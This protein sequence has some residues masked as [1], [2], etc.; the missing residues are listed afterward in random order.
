M[1][2]LFECW[3]RVS[4]R[5]RASKELRV[6]LDFDGTLV[7]YKPHPNEVELS[8]KTAR[9]LGK[10]AGHRSVRVAIVSGRR[11]DAL[12]KYVKVR[13]VK[14]MGM[15]GWENGTS[16]RLSNGTAEQIRNFRSG[17]ATLPEDLPGVSV[18]DKGISV[19]VHFRGVSE[20]TKRRA[21]DRVRMG[22][23]L[24]HSDLH[25]IRSND[26]WDVAPTQVRGKGEALRKALKGTRPD[27][28]AIYVGDDAT[29]ESAFATLRRGI[30]I[31]AGPARKTKARYG[32]KNPEEVCVFLEKLESEIAIKE[33]NQ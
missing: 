20:A 13:G 30:T 4:R 17:I 15:Y 25:V 22:L 32:V 2:N 26:V 31:L 28:L 33:K 11:R 27:A 6:Y 14:F 5:V 23:R 12:K 24:D 1:R 18:E 9:A 19:A 3:D 21:Q 10:L 7:D 29:D 16:P 8:E